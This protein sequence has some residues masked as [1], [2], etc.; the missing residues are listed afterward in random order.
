[1]AKRAT[2]ADVAEAAGVS[3]ATV[4]RVLN[5]RFKVRE[6]TAQR[7]Y[8]AALQVGYYAAN[9]IGSRLQHHLPQYRLGVL[10]QRPNQPFYQQLANTLAEHARQSSTCRIVLEIEFLD[11]QIPSEVAARLRQMGQRVQA[12]AITTIEHATINGVVSEL[13]GRNVPVFSLLSDI[14][15]G[16]REGYV[17]V[18]NRKAGRTAAWLISRMARG[19]GKVGIF[20]GSHRFW[21]HEMREIGFRT[22][23]REHAPQFE[24][25]DTLLNLEARQITHEA[26]LE[27]LGRY[28][29]LVGFYVAGGGME[30]AISA[31]REEQRA[32]QLIVVCNELTPDSRSALADG[33]LTMVIATPVADLSRELLAQMVKAVENGVGSTTGQGI[34]PFVVYTSENI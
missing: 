12:V 6:G 28:P 16:I 25:I 34:L 2:I 18:D 7:V 17:G 3:V 27:L 11:S 22:Y 32:G 15:P 19:A 24:V 29:D 8:E 26:T 30:G 31:L 13:K 21:G 9:V 4:D 10:L 23:F 14:A 1:M 5:G 33:T 20:V